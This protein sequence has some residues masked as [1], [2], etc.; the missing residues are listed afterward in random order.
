MTH[1]PPV[2][3]ISLALVL[4]LVV[5]LSI[6]LS[7]GRGAGA[8]IS[9]Q[10]QNAQDAK[11][12]CQLLAA[13]TTA[14]TAQHNRA[15]NCVNDQTTIINLL[16]AP[17]PSPS[18][19]VTSTPPP[20]PSPTPTTPSPS[21]TPSPT[22][23]GPLTN[24]AAAPGACGFPDATST[25]AHGTLA[26]Y[27]GPST[28]TTPGLTIHDVSITKCLVVT[29]PNV[30][31]RNVRI[32][33]NGQP[34]LV[35][36]GTVRDGA[37]AYDV[38]QMAFDHVTLICT[39]GAGT[40]IGEARVIAI[41]VDISGCENGFDLDTFLD[42]EDSYIHDMAH[43]GSLH[44]DGAQI[45]PGATN[46]LVRHNSILMCCLDNST[47]TIGHDG[48]TP[49]TASIVSNLLVGGNFIVYCHFGS[50]ELT[51]NRWGS[52]HSTDGNAPFGY[53]ADCDGLTRSGNVLDA[54][55]A[56]LTP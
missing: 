21:P 44:T 43:G 16:T 28:I 42:V 9:T 14:G 20:S 37:H 26:T 36:N 50:G 24:C 23:T 25:G 5:A 35:D 22:P 45:W 32:A 30:S 56:P 8:S 1:R 34:Y 17:S 38:G 7:S 48:E 27:T 29:A 3:Q 51:S 11:A 47:L 40:A 52:L 6:V 19:T 49:V 39:G 54:T 10:L 15:V 2:R 53:T 41:A 55:G 33:C 18:P 12:N 13:N 4:G 31:F 46:I